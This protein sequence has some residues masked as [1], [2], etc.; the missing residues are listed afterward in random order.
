VNPDP[1]TLYRQR[2]AQIRATLREIYAALDQHET[3]QAQRPESWGFAADA[4]AAEITLRQAL[5]CLTAG[6]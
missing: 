2:T 4:A 5:D 3:K 6:L 1:A